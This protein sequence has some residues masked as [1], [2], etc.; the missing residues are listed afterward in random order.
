M[1]RAHPGHD[2]SEEPLQEGSWSLEPREDAGEG[3][4]SDP[5]L[6]AWLRQRE[7]D[8]EEQSFALADQMTEGW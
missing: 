3:E 4:E 5:E 6:E 8:L 7:V 1:V 2:E